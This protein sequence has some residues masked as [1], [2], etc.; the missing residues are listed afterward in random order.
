MTSRAHRDQVWQKVLDSPEIHPDQAPGEILETLARMPRKHEFLWESWTHSGDE[1]PPSRANM[2]VGADGVRRSKLIHRAGTTAC[3]RWVPHAESPYTGLL[4]GVTHGLLRASTTTAGGAS[5]AFTPGIAIKLFRADGSTGNLLAAHTFEGVHPDSIAFFEHP[6]STCVPAPRL[7]KRR[8][9]RR[10]QWNATVGLF[11]GA[12]TWRDKRPDPP[13][14]LRIDVEPFCRIDAQGEPVQTVVAPRALSFHAPAA[15]QAVL[16]AP[17]SVDFRR[18]FGRLVGTERLCDVVDESGSP[19]GHLQLE[20]AFRSSRYGAEKLFF[21]HTHHPKVDEYD[22][23]T[24][25]AGC[26]NQ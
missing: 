1:V 6:L 21:Q 26:P 18:R 5:D 20:S 16:D 22:C 17:P 8:M 14:E 2:D 12:L 13:S 10:V 7:P 19:V 4:A 11:R 3:V 9:F 24:P 25:R 23:G 15:I